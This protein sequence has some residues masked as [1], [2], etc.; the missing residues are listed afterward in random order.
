LGEP[1]PPDWAEGGRAREEPRTDPPREEPRRPHAHGEHECLEWCP[2]CRTAE[3]VR[4][5]FPPEV[6]SQL[7][8]VQRDALVA[9]RT[10]LDHYIDRLDADD[11]PA[12]RV[13]DIPI[14]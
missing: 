7:E 5:S 2:I 12:S 11:R 6:R 4:A 9:I 1:L 3:I 8:D 10:V 13:E 14:S